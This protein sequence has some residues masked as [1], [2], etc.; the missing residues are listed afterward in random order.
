MTRLNLSLEDFKVEN[1]YDG[2][3]TG[4]F[5]SHVS[6]QVLFKVGLTVELTEKDLYPRIP[7]TCLPNP[8]LTARITVYKRVSPT[9]GP[10]NTQ[11]SWSH[12]WSRREGG[13]KHK[14]KH[15][16]TP[17][18]SGLREAWR[19]DFQHKKKNFDF[20]YNSNGFCSSLLLTLRTLSAGDGSAHFAGGT[21]RIHLTLSYILNKSKTSATKILSK[22]LRGLFV[23]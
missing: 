2:V 4:R 17:V 21:L 8:Y 10:N 9:P 19:F 6:T 5:H 13:S 20:F 15:V 16:Q 12:Q 22:W 23:Y 3:T 18:M 11:W 1:R 7:L 14:C